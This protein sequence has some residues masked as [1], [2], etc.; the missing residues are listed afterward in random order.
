MPKILAALALLLLVS[1]SV[2]RTLSFR[3]DELPFME[4]HLEI[5]FVFIYGDAVIATGGM[6]R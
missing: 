3:L 4:F 5:T 6:K 2:W 1:F